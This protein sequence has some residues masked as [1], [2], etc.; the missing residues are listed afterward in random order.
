[1]IWL[2]AGLLAISC[3]RGV[4]CSDDD[5]GG[6]KFWKGEFT[7]PVSA[8]TSYL[9][10]YYHITLLRGSILV[11]NTTE[12]ER[13]ILPN[14]RQ[15]HC[16]ATPCVKFR[17]NSKLRSIWLPQLSFINCMG[18]CVNKVVMHLEGDVLEVTYEDLENLRFL[19]G[20][21]LIVVDPVPAAYEPQ[22]PPPRNLHAD[23]VLDYLCVAL[24]TFVVMN[25]IISVFFCIGK[26][27]L[28]MLEDAMMG[29]MLEVRKTTINAKLNRYNIET[30]QRKNP[31]MTFTEAA[32]N[33]QSSSGEQKNGTSQIRPS[34][35]ALLEMIAKKEN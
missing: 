31:S 32:R 18:D 30:L 6:S 24:I 16:K 23:T 8:N 13:F 27:R 5:D 1:M 3:L 34:R 21:R 19:T 15:I 17:N 12:L 29:E 7:V 25:F 10:Q 26:L 2:V 4:F 14:L 22:K 9:E 33:V 35:A 11:E 20:D 28:K